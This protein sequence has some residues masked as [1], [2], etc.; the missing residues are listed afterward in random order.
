MWACMMVA[1]LAVLGHEPCDIE[2]LYFEAESVKNTGGHTD[3]QGL[4]GCVNT[5]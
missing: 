3:M 4:Q 1:F 5:A 2:L